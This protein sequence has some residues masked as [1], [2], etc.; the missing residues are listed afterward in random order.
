MPKSKRSKIFHLTKTKKKGKT[1]KEKLVTEMHDA[2]D[3]FKHCYVFKCVNMRNNGLKMLR[4]RWKD[5]SVFMGKNK[6]M[7]L[8]LGKSIESEHK[9]GLHQVAK[10][11]QGP[12]GVLFTNM[13]PDTVKEHLSEVREIHFARSGFVATEDFALEEGEINMPFS[14]ETQLRKYGLTTSLKEGKILLSTHTQVCK[15]GDQLT[16]EQC[17]L[18][19][20]FGVKMAEFRMYASCH[21]EAENGSFEE[22]PTPDF[23]IE[24]VGV[25]VSADGF[26]GEWMT[27]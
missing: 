20:L 16:P 17:K 6:V 10:M 26:Q 9:D 14:M 24:N 2:A 13:E 22:Y 11:V 15:I 27:D 12:C 19:E 4:N 21:W 7:A 5:S 18:L 23:A 3:K 1:V 25:A 8:A